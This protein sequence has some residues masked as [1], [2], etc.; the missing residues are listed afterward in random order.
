MTP[1]H[2]TGPSGREPS[3]PSPS[4]AAPVPEGGL[5]K[6]YDPSSFE[7]KWQAFWEEKGLFRA[8]A[9]NGPGP[10]FTIVLPPPNVTGILTFGHSL[11]GTVQDT[12]V[13]WQRMKGVPTL[14]LP[15]VDH[16]GVATQMAVRKDLEKRGIEA[17]KL[18][19]EEL[20]G[21]IQAWKQEKELYIRRQLTRHGFSLD[22]SR[23]VYTMDP[24]YS[25][26]VRTAFL[27]LYRAG[28]VY[29]AER[30]VN[31]DPKLLTALSD[32]EVI[33]KEVH[34][35]LY[36]VRY[37]AAEG[38]GIVVA[39][40]RPETMFGDV[41]VA[42][43]PEDDRHRGKI[44]TKVRLPLTER[45]I[46]VIA[47]K[48][49]D[50]TF[51]NGALKITPS[52]DPVDHEI[53][54]RHPELPSRRESLDERG[55]LTGEFVPERWRGMDRAKARAEIVEALRGQGFLVK[56]EPHVHNVGHSER[57]D[58]PIEPR[59]SWQWFA[60]TSKMGLRA[61]EAVRNGDV[62]IVPD[63]WVPTYYHFMENLRDWCISRQVVWGH[64]IPV[65]YC[66]TC[67]GVDA[68]EMPPTGCPKC[69]NPKLRQDP[70][71]LDTWF[72]S[73]LWPFAT[74]GWPSV[75][76]D[77]GTYSPVS[78]LVTGS[79]IVFFWVARMI[80]AGLQFRDAPPF[81]DV[82][83]TGILTDRQGRKLSKHLGNSPDPLELID[84]WGADAFRFALLFP[85]P[86]DE[87]GTWDPQRMMEGG[88]NF[89][90]KLWNL[91]RLVQM[92][93]PP[94]SPA[95]SG[96]PALGL[97]SPLVDR[98]I[99]SRLSATVA[100]VD[101]SLRAY[102]MTPAASTLYNFLWHEMADWWAEAAK[103]RLTGREGK[104]AQ[105]AAGQVGLY[106]LERLLRLL[107]PFVPHITEELWQAFPHEG[108]SLAVARWPE[109]A[110]VPRDP[111]AEEEGS[112]L[113]EVVRG[114]RTL[115]ADARLPSEARSPAS[116]LA[117]TPAASAVLASPAERAVVQRLA[118]L[119]SISSLGPSAS[120][121]PGAYSLVVPGWEIFLP[122]SGEAGATGEASV[123]LRKE[124]ELVA[125]LLTK[126]RARLADPTFRG[127]APPAVVA[128]A[129]AKAQELEKRLSD[130]D[131]HLGASAGNGV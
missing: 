44:G 63:R 105:A 124:R 112:A 78:V 7:A 30:M 43:N 51:G 48:A 101:E 47:D 74:L 26:A 13:R 93:L 75:T 126:A 58:V 80:M 55:R 114:I 21:L 18:G 100:A 117:R 72:S 110:E 120:A 59:L 15:G 118:K 9:G 109:A 8:P 108:S 56:E 10:H 66:D 128:E 52:H 57:S 69:G 119:E 92:G 107:H 91:A 129:E 88:R 5:P 98:W 82:Y 116:L 131:R 39:T 16:A 6:R 20:H 73:W 64:P 67:G 113:Q 96:P 99:V 77:L 1:T 12:L 102:D 38:E 28:L 65:W 19:R 94:V 95:P 121:P 35:H 90:T 97:S 24:G 25:S 31:W 27:T 40:T 45:D 111:R 42:V 46:P 17:A 89:L 29:R 83:L 4:P 76:P 106:V 34:G 103:D 84:Q 36:Y 86:V 85:N 70:D 2:E 22:W 32:L 60:D 14:W 54:S 127:K 23:Y 50:P 104:E 68:Y 41:A 62:R 37:P 130:L 122:R 3:A 11:G 125:N 123:A 115:R 53:A 79:D 33:P 71:V 87:G 61:L 49:V 81:R